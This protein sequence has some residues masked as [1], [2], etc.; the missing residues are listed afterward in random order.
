MAVIRKTPIMLITGS[1]GSGKTTLL[2]RILDSRALSYR[3]P[4]E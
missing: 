1:L 4:H 2:R 3:G